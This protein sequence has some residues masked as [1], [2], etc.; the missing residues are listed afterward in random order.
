MF[1]RIPHNL[2]LSI[3]FGLLKLVLCVKIFGLV[4]IMLAVYERIKFHTR[5]RR[6]KNIIRQNK[7]Y[8]LMI[9][10]HN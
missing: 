4:Y 2:K 1:L 5:T 10:D 8:Y 9:Q 3:N 6:Y 7:A